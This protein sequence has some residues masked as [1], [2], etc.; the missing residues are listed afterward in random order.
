[1]DN[2]SYYG[3]ILFRADEPFGPAAF[4]GW[5]RASHTVLCLVGVGVEVS[6]LTTIHIDHGDS[7]F[8]PP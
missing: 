2:T 3:V 1:M 8:H 5:M 4:R 6:L 7:D